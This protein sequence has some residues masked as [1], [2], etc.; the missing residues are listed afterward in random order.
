MGALERIYKQ[1][2]AEGRTADAAPLYDI[3]SRKADLAVADVGERTAALAEMAALAA[4][5]L[6]RPDDAIAAWEQVL[7]AHPGH[8]EA[9]PAL[10]AMYR[11]ERRW[12]DLVDLYERRLGFV[13]TLDEAIAL[14][15]KLGGLHEHELGD[16]TTAI[17]SYAAALG[18]DPGHAGAIAAL[19]RLLGNADGRAAAAEV[20]EPVYIAR[21]DW[22]ALARLYEVQLDGQSEPDAASI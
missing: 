11:R 17:E 2:L 6:A 16:V 13:E 19:E 4:G 20:L 22:T 18:G 7:E 9:V 3:L 10:D 15:V 8:P 21:H 12:R 14:R 1:R 5:P